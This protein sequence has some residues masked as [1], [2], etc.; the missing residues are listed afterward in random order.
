M[1][2]RRRN[3]RCTAVA[4]SILM[5]SRTQNILHC[6]A[7]I[8]FSTDAAARLCARRALQQWYLKIQDLFFQMLCRSFTYQEMQTYE[9]ESIFLKQHVYYHKTEHQNTKPI[10]ILSLPPQCLI[11]LMSYEMDVLNAVTFHVFVIHLPRIKARVIIYSNEM[12][13]CKLRNEQHIARSSIPS[14]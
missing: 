11:I 12:H 3:A 8:L 14:A 10:T 5:N 2:K 9:T 6:R 1:L 7:A 4:D 13:W